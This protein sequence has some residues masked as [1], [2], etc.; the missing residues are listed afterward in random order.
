MKIHRKGAAA[1]GI[2][3]LISWAVYGIMSKQQPSELLKINGVPVEAEEFQLFLDQK[4]PKVIGYFKEKYGAEDSP[5]FWT[6]SYSG[7]IPIDMAK[8]LALEELTHVKI[9]QL[10]SKENGLLE[11]VSYSSFLD[12]LS[13]ENERRKEAVRKKQ[14][15]YGPKKYDEWG[16]YNYL[17]SNLVIKL[18]EKLAQEGKAISEQE[19]VAYYTATKDKFYKKEDSTKIQRLVVSYTDQTGNADPKSKAG[20]E[21]MVKEA[22]R[23]VNKGESFETVIHAVRQVDSLKLRVEEQVFDD[24]SAKE[25]Y[26]ANAELKEHAKALEVGGI[27]QA[28]EWDNAY[29]IIKVLDRTPGGYRPF[30]EVKDDVKRRYADDQYD[31]KVEQLVGQANIEMNSE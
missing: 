22:Y 3:I 27:S 12:N 26:R 9:Q 14:V 31:R 2:L 7:E 5:S 20:A 13:R 30:D 24:R 21:E 11:D 8:Q 19:A 10:L 17:F 23:L 25:D 18:K 15:I 6:T 16:Y 29:M 28:F 4:R 1:V